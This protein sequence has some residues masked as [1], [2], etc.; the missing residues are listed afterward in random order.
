MP[1]A[2][3]LTRGQAGRPL[4]TTARTVTG[5]QRWIRGAT[6]VA[7]I[8]VSLVLLS[9]A[10]WMM[11]AFLQVTG[12]E[13][14][15]E[16]RHLMTFDVSMPGAGYDA[17]RQVRF[18]DRLVEQVAA[19]PGVTHAATAMPMPLARHP[20]GMSFA[21]EGRPSPSKGRPAAEMAIVSSGYF[22]TMRT[23]LVAGRDF[24]DFDDGRQPRVAIVNQA[25]ADKFFP[26]QS[27]LGMRIQPGA[28]GPYDE[29]SPLR[30]IVG[31]VGNVRQSPLAL[32][33]E[34]VFYLP[35][36][37]MPWGASFVVRSELSPA[38][39]LPA[40]RAATSALE[41]RAAVHDLHGFDELL[42]R[43]VA[44]PQLVVLLIGSFA[45]T[46]LLLTTIGLYG[47]LAYSV[48]QRTREIGVRMALGAQRSAIVSM[49]TGE[50]LI[51]VAAGLALGGSGT[52]V[53]TA[54]LR[55]RWSFPGPPLTLTLAVACVTVLLTAAVSASVPARRAAGVDP[56]QA[57][58][59]E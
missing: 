32:G 56:T 27:P 25:F 41:G 6:V 15:F 23:A 20:I 18:V 10:A 36:R 12:R 31:V 17:D 16:S 14:G 49:V 4:L 29:G 44:G 34:P 26:G 5:S 57:L 38:S 48:Q 42:T 33:P 3:R 7:Q 11:T 28:T 30:G 54:V 19:L 1:A 9:A 39:L 13:L 55:S 58:R 46:A 52:L 8:A 51:L 47:L 50:A 22:A 2:L 40:L 24:A 59:S 43:G 35:F 45:A 37:Q 53:A 21:I